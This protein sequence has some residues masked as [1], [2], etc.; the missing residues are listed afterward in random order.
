MARIKEIERIWVDLPLKEVPFRNMVREIPHWSLFEICK[1][2]LDTGHV[3]LGETM[4]YYTYGAVSDAAVARAQGGSPTELMWDD[5]LGAGLQMAIFDAVGKLI[6]A[7]LWSLF[8]KRIRNWAH[9]GWWAIDMPADD[10]ILECQEA[11]QQGYTTFK[12]KARPWFDLH[13]QLERLCSSVPDYFQIDMD[14]N[15]FGLD[16]AVARP[17]CRALEK[18]SKIAIWE[19]PI[20]QED[21][22]GN[23][24][25]R[26]QLSVPIAQH[27][28]RP[29]FRT[30]LERQICDGFVMEGGVS[31]T[32]SKGRTCEEFNKP[33]WLQWVGS[34]LAASFCLHLQAVLTH[35]R[36]PAI[37]CNHMYAAQYVREPW[38][39]RNGQA[40]VP[41]QPGIGVTVDW[42]VV[43]KY[44]IEPKP[45]PYPYPRLL[46][47]LDW[48][49][50]ACS[51]FTHAQQLWDAFKYAELPSFTR[52]VNL[53]RVLDDGGENWRRLY[54]SASRQPILYGERMP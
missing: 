37:H 10:W 6:G 19:S 5:T 21:V 45:K 32:L 15:D 39:V 43:E 20:Q 34:N 46:L 54:D 26:A 44:R 49:S 50:G 47:R 18:H 25:L 28:G 9:V 51:Y 23:R 8:G 1:V 29:A 24:S 41:D 16:P 33:Y 3:G 7:P 40:Q 52:G 42:K 48:P 4:P 13:D 30:Q 14:F 11:V 17:L 53:T 38:Q 35:A 36:W 2:T 12:T 31:N 27:T 22:E